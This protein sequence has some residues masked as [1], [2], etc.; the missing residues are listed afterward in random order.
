MVLTCRYIYGLYVWHWLCRRHLVVDSMS[1]DEL[2][3]LFVAIWE[4]TVEQIKEKQ[5][6]PN[7]DG[8]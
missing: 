4:H 3:A 7:R 2:M 5:Y 6:D 1:K 8:S